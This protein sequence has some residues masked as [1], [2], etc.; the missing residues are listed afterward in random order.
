[1][2][3]RKCS[4][5]K[6]NKQS[7]ECDIYVKLLLEPLEYTIDMYLTENKTKLKYNLYT[8]KSIYMYMP[9]IVWEIVHY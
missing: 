8:I 4:F 1:M 6:H 3:L 7:E 2:F 5:L 9:I